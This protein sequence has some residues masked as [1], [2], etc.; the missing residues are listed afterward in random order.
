MAMQALST[1]PQATAVPAFRPISAAAFSVIV[2]T[3]AWDGRISG[4]M[5]AGMPAALSSS[6]HISCLTRSYAPLEEA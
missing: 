6:A 1:P 3:I 5:E 2:P 4:Q